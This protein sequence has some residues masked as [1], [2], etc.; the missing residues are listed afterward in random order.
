LLGQIL[1]LCYAVLLLVLSPALVWKRIR[2]GKYRRGWSQKLCGTLPVRQDFQRPLIWFHAVS[3]GEVMQLRQVLAC[4]QAR[5]PALQILITTTTETGFDVAREKFPEHAVAFLPLDFTWAVRQALRRVRPDLVVLVELELW[6]NFLREAARQQIPVAL[7]NGRLSPRSHRGYSRVKWL[8]EP[9]LLRFSRI[10]VQSAEYRDRFLSLGADPR[11]IS[12]TGSIKFDGVVTDRGNPRTQA[13]RDWL[14]LQ[15]D[16]LVFIAGS[17][18][19]PEEDYAVDVYQRLLSQLPQLRL[20]IVPRHPERGPAILSLLRQRGMRVLQ[21]SQ[22]GILPMGT[23]PLVGLLDTVGELGAC[24]GMA[25]VAFVGGSF[26]PRGG[27]NMLEPAAYGAAVCHGPNTWN[28]RQVV[29]LF[30]QSQATCTV[31]NPEELELFVRTMLTDRSQAQA[32][33]QRAQQIVLSQQGAT[34]RT[35][36]LLLSALDRQPAGDTSDGTNRASR[37]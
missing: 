12:I 1:N 29:E 25:D 2:V 4:L 10:G 36:D 21:R 35:V 28:F 8:I 18:S 31:Q 32:M 5:A 7:V 23:G 19:E 37:E 33:G 20:V 34:A 3:V 22:P 17:T 24:W 9:L 16:E 6:P 27:Q 14:Q 11:S 13:L 30:A 26:G 15:P